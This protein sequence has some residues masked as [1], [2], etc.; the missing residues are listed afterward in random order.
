MDAARMAPLLAL[1][2]WCIPLVWPQSGE[3]HVSSA[4][5]IIYIF[6]IWFALVVAKALSARA[7]KNATSA[8]EADRGDDG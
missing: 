6:A 7:L 2:L 3:G 4:T 1:A 5:A 8:D